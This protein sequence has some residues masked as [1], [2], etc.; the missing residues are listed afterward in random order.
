M[1]AAHAPE[2][3]GARTLSPHA[4]RTHR[5]PSRALH[6][7]LCGS[8]HG[9]GAHTGAKRTRRVGLSVRCAR[10]LLWRGRLPRRAHADR[11]RQSV[12]AA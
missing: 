2:G 12:R 4:C 11:S 3:A 9:S 5:A 6:A 1:W 8:A 10:R 7:L